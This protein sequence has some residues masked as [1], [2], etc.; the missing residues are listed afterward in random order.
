DRLCGFR[1]PFDVCSSPKPTRLLRGNEMT[2]RA[3]TGL[4]HRSKE[5]AILDHLVGAGEQCRGN[6]NAERPGGFY[7]DRELKFDRLFDG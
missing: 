5:Q 6:V 3:T 7:I 2:R 1:P 4:M